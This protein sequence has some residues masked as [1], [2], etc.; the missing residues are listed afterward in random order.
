MRGGN[1]LSTAV[2]LQPRTSNPQSIET[3]GT[4]PSRSLT[5]VDQEAVDEFPVATN[6]VEPGQ[7]HI[8]GQY[9]AA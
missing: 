4:G 8:I 6:A 1:R 5:G 9:Y 7:T 2:S 3:G